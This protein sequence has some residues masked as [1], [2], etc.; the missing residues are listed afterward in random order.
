MNKAIKLKDK[1]KNNVYPCP[2]FPVG[3]I[4]LS[5]INVNPAEYFGGTWV[6]V[7]QGRFLVGVGTV[8]ENNNNW[9]GKTNAGQWTCWE[10]DL[11]GE[12]RHTISVGEL[13][14]HTHT[15]RNYSHNWN[16]GVTIPAY[17]SYAQS[18]NNEYGSWS[19][20]TTDIPNSE[21]NEGPETSGT[22]SGWDMNNLP[23]YY[24]VYVWRRVA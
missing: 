17:H 19:W 2:Y 11:G 1:D 23:P 6:R 12:C 20:T 4:Y 8:E 18:Y 21:I 22:G 14:H 24:S 3:S 5:A 9:C 16:S 10:N 15:V 7:S 13:P